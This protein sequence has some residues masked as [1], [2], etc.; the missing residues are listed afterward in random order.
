MLRELRHA[1]LEEHQRRAEALHLLVGEVAGLD[2][3]QRL[4]FYQ[5]AQQP[6][7]GQHELD[8]P[9]ARRCPGAPAPQA[10]GA[11]RPPLR[12]S[13]AARWSGCHGWRPA[14]ATAPQ[15]S[16]RGHPGTRLRRL[17]GNHDASPEQPEGAWFALASR[18][19][20]RSAPLGVTS[21]HPSSPLALL[22]R[23]PR[24]RPA[25]Q[26]A[27]PPAQLPTGHGRIVRSAGGRAVA[28][29]DLQVNARPVHP[30][31]VRPVP[32]VDGRRRRSPCLG[33]VRPGCRCAGRA[34][35]PTATAAAARG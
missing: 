10:P 28:A 3:P 14:A 20:E 35:P 15:R 27:A 24:S 31:W 23:L 16:V 13:P 4:A 19:Q 29:A 5:L 11:R 30:G 12:W 9:T 1:L 7:H 17:T 32:G 18:T 25:A 34:A 26:G 2:S 21:R 33:C 8:Q 22:A 6:R